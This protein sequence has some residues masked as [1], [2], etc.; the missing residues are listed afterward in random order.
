MPAADINRKR[1]KMRMSSRFLLALIAFVVGGLLLGSPALAELPPGVADA[2]RDLR[3]QERELKEEQDSVREAEGDLRDANTE[4]RDAKT[5][6]E[7]AKRS[8]KSFE[9]DYKGFKKLI[10]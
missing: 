8:E 7:I 2:Q 9:D 3:K 5:D 4:Y 6:W 10:S 1:T